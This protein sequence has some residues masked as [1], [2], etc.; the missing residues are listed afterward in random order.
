MKYPYF[1]KDISK[2]EKKGYWIPNNFSQER[3]D[4]WE[5][6]KAQEG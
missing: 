1:E 2:L 5:G 4:E 6:R 3:W